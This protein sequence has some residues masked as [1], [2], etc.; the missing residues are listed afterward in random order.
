MPVTPGQNFGRSVLNAAKALGLSVRLS[1]ALTGDRIQRCVSTIDPLAVVNCFR[2][3]TSGR[4]S[5]RRRAPI[6]AG[7]SCSWCRGGGEGV[8]THLPGTVL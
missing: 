7:L 6:H 2:N 5:T 4:L 8:H 3:T 1:P